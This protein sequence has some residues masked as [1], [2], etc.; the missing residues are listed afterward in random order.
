MNHQVIDNFSRSIFVEV[1]VAIL[2][3]N[4]DKFEFGKTDIFSFLSISIP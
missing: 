1:F 4:S 3:A 2:C